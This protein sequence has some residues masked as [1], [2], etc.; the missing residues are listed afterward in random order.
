MYDSS[1]ILN[2]KR[3]SDGM[4]SEYC[5][6]TINIAIIKKYTSILF[7]GEIFHRIPLV[8]KYEP[9]NSA[10]TLS[11]EENRICLFSFIV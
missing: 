7:V 4:H 9:E 1:K 11:L 2:F 8:H 3:V 6:G 10:K 5:L